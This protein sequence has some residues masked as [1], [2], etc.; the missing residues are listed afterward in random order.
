[1]MARLAALIALQFGLVSAFT[2][3]PIL[4]GKRALCVRVNEQ[5]NYTV[6][7]VMGSQ[8][9]AKLDKDFAPDEWCDTHRDWYTLWVSIEQLVPLVIDCWM[10]NTRLG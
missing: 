6:P 10:N 7:G 8:L 5:L 2:S 4:I 3:S 1:M 9:E